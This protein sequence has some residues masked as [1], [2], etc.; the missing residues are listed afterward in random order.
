M[1]DLNGKLV[2]VTGAASGIGRETAKALAREK[3]RLI[4]C[5][6]NEAGLAEIAGEVTGISECVL[7]KVVDVSDREGM[8]TFAEEVHAAHGPLDVLV[9]NAGVGI[10]SSVLTT[11]LEDWDWVIDINLKGVVH[12]LHFFLP[13]MVERGTGG[14]VVNVASLAGYFVSTGLTAY[15]TTK[16][17][18]FGLSE[19]AREDLREFDIGVSTIC[20]GVIKTGIVSSS[21]FRGF[22][23]P[24]EI[25]DHIAQHY[26]KRNYGPDRVANAIVTAIR[27]NKGI[28]PV[29]PESWMFY[30]INRL[31]VP[32]SRRLGRAVKDKMVK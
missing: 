21:R 24:D 23:N 17:G 26:V 14:H 12:G 3:A 15:L 5:D 7:S 22:D 31:C 1:R 19:A 2:L 20:P 25:R 9:N 6:V 8:R 27:K 4:L 13:P 32:L 28:V 16:F 30:Y 18:I 10:S 11:T 29:S